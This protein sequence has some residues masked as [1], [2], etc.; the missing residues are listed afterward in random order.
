VRNHHDQVLRDELI[1]AL[2]AV[3]MP[4]GIS[5]RVPYGVF[6]D[7]VMR[8]GHIDVVL[9]RTGEHLYH[10]THCRHGDP[11]SCVDDSNGRR[12]AQC[13]KCAAPCRH[14]YEDTEG[15]SAA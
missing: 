10:S 7:V 2:R 11:E 15:P 14:T 4:A 6:A 1:R 9:H 8:I 12:P 3:P 13:K 5:S